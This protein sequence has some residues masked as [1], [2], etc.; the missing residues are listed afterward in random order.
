[1]VRLN[2]FA[3]PCK[4]PWARAGDPSR[5]SGHKSNSF[6]RTH[7]GDANDGPLRRGVN[8]TE[9][10]KRVLNLASPSQG[11]MQTLRQPAP[12]RGE[13]SGRSRANLDGPL[14]MDGKLRAGYSPCPTVPR[15]QVRMP[16][17]RQLVPARRS[18]MP[19][20][21]TRATER[22]VSAPETATP[23]IRSSSP[24]RM[25]P[26][27]RI[28][29][30]CALPALKARDQGS[31]QCRHRQL[32]PWS[33]PADISLAMREVHALLRAPLMVSR[34][35]APS[36][37]CSRDNRS[38]TG[39]VGVCVSLASSYPPQ[40]PDAS[41]GSSLFLEKTQPIFPS[42]STLLRHASLS[43]EWYCRQGLA[44][45]RSIRPGA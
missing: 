7:R 6:G 15:D 40:E 24:G 45:T 33:A 21:T 17:T 37:S 43:A 38:G 31:A 9:R 8:S 34:N 36:P 12:F 10:A 1:M 25:K 39:Y 27:P 13:G 2:S 5:R 28:P 42:V 23:S 26:C 14:A 3:S 19:C 32:G 30:D 44:L 35:P 22:R 18:L 16:L 29:R 41:R 11:L 20:W 4:C